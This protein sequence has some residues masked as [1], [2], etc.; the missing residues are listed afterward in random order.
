MN[1]DAESTERHYSPH[2]AVPQQYVG[3]AEAGH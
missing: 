3:H 2:Q 1:G